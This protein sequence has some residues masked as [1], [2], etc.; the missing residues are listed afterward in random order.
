MG[1][2]ALLV[3]DDRLLAE[4]MAEWLGSQDFKCDLV[5]RGDE[6]LTWLATYQYDIAVID[7]QMPGLAGVDVIKQYRASGGACSILMLTG[8]GAIE[9]KEQGL[10]AGADDYLTK[11]F[12]YLELGARI[13]ALLR[14]PATFVQEDLV[15]GGLVLSLRSRTLRKNGENVSLTPNEFAIIQFFLRHPTEVLGNE[16]LILRIWETDTDVTTDAIYSSIKRLRKKLGS[17]IIENVHGLGY[18]L[19]NTD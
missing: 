18:R 12:S 3:E 9:E 10:D 1:F 14:R 6:A 4:A 8:R 5:H 13:R 16:A 7:W 19:G 15:R 2:K 17:G 11:P